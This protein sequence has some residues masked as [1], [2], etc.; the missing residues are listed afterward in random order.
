MQNHG[1]RGFVRGVG[2]EEASNIG[3]YLRGVEIR[4]KIQEDPKNVEGLRWKIH[5]DAKVGVQL[6]GGRGTE[7]RPSR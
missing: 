4:K 3:W 7:E 2:G 5:G 1:G 6:Q